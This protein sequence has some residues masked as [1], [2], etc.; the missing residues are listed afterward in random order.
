MEDAIEKL[1]DID[2]ET[3]HRRTS[4]IETDSSKRWESRILPAFRA[5]RGETS[6]V[7]VQ[8]KRCCSLDAYDSSRK[9]K[10]KQFFLF[11]NIFFN[12][13]Y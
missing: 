8:R 11:P 6:S 2:L 3:L 10:Y 5:E 1:E 13:L 4:S 9:C 12:L 7:P